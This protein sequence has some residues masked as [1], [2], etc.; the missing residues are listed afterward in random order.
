ME[1]AL[2]VFDELFGDFLQPDDITFSTLV[3]GYGEA[4][5]PQW[6]G[7]STVLATMQQRFGMRPDTA[8]YTSLLSICARTKDD[9]RGYEI[10]ERMARTGVEPDDQVLDAVGKRKSLR[11]HLR[12][13]YT[14]A[15]AG[16]GSIQHDSMA[17]GNEEGSMAA[18]SEQEPNEELY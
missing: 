9:D 2:S 6:S 1:M 11:S 12:R 17:A 8:V 18:G 14:S 10:I 16:S 3:R 15:S 13:V 7:I 5:P 4:E